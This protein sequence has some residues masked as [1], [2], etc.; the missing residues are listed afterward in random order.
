MEISPFGRVI[1]SLSLVSSL[2]EKPVFTRLVCPFC[3]V[4]LGK[5][6]RERYKDWLILFECFTVGH[7]PHCN[8]KR[9]EG[10]QNEMY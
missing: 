10:C 9:F 3:G 7:G 2:I 1:A 4:R 6:Y 8:T 5:A